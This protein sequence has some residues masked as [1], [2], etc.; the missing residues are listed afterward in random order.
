[1]PLPRR[2]ARFPNLVAESGVIVVSVEPKSPAERA[3]LSEG[4][5]IVGYGG[6][7][8]SG[9]DDLHRLLTD[10]QAGLRVAL[11][12]VRRSENIVLDIVPEES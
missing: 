9:I 11:T 5:V 8:V 6:Q 4:D 10:E 3:G 1:M 2:V 7:P 12:V